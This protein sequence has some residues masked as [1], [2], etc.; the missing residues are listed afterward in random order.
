MIY[1]SAQPVIFGVKHYAD[2][3]WEVVKKRG[4]QVNLRHNLVEVRPDKK[5]AVF[6]NLEKP[7][8]QKIVDVS[9]NLTVKGEVPCDSFF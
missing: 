3:L 7:E 1:N 9:L 2:S 5:Q 6:Q 4:I 8:E